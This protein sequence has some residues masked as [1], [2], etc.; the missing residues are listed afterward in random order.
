MDA[1]LEKSRRDLEA[2]EDLPAGLAS[3]LLM[4]EG[5]KPV[6]RELHPIESVDEAAYRWHQLG[7][8]T[9]TGDPILEEQLTGAM[10]S[11]A[12]SEY[13]IRPLRR[14]PVIERLLQIGGRF[15]ERWLL[16]PESPIHRKLSKHY[17]ADITPERPEEGS[18]HIVPKQALYI[19][20]TQNLTEEARTLDRMGQ[21]SQD[22]Q[23]AELGRLLGYPP[24]CVAAFSRLERRWPNRLPMTHSARR[25][26]SFHPRLN[27]AALDRF[28]YISW[29]PCR[30]DCEPSIRLANRA[31]EALERLNPHIVAAIDATLA[32]PR[33]YWNDH[34]QGVL[35]NCEKQMDMLTFAEI[36]DL[37]NVWPG[38]Q[39]TDSDDVFGAFESV[40]AVTC[41]P[42]KPRFFAGRTRIEIPTEPLLLPF[43][44][45]R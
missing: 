35:K 43:L 17:H 29:F 39:E 44:P 23:T 10:V 45:L 2:I 26:K 28:A 37:H 27:N 1:N 14:H 9:A 7:Y 19:S 24:C 22:D 4:E 42:T 6:L 33:L 34:T 20:R 31:A 41:N 16:D 13:T 5:L 38:H 36:E 40:N 11:R 25:S 30:Y 8:K 21:D 15:A 32:M 3:Q 12:N 18:R